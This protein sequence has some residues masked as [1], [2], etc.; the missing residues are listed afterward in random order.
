MRGHIRFYSNAKCVY[1][2]FMKARDLTTGKF[3][4]THGKSYHALYKTWKRMH[5]RCYDETNNRYYRYGARGIKVC[6]RWHDI[7]NFINDMGKKPD[8]QHS[9]DRIDND[10][11]YEPSNCRWATPREQVLNR[12]V[13]SKSKSGVAGVTYDKKSGKWRVRVMRNY[14]SKHIGLYEELDEAVKARQAWQ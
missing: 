13:F 12:S 4:K 11:D 10:G 14:S 9:L 7:D 6:K 1:N 3:T 8:E 2:G 5:S